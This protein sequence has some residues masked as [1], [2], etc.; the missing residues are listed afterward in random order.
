VEMKYIYDV[1][2]LGYNSIDFLI[3]LPSFPKK[4]TKMMVIDSDLQGGGQV[5]TA[6]VALSRW[7][8]STTYV[9]SIGDDENGKISQRE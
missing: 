8:I 7:G 4:N 2:G 5:A 3:K 9:G 6:L 1:V